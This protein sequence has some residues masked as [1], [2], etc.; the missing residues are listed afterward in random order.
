M[1]KSGGIQKIAPATCRDADEIAI[2]LKVAL[3]T[4]P[5]TE[6]YNVQKSGRAVSDSAYHERKEVMVIFKE[7]KFYAKDRCLQEFTFFNRN[8]FKFIGPS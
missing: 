2:C 3:I 5:Q 6:D 7:Y 8:L 4:P 1:K